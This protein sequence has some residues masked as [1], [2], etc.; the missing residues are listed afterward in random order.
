MVSWVFKEFFALILLVALHELRSSNFKESVCTFLRVNAYVYYGGLSVRSFHD[1]FKE[2]C[3]AKNGLS[4]I[5]LANKGVTHSSL[6]D[7]SLKPLGHHLI[8]I[9]IV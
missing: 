7:V 1:I 5:N 9:A 2:V 4:T 3:D 8:H 6:K